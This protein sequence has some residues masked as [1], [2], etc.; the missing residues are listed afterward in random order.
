MQFRHHE[1]VIALPV[2]N[3]GNGAIAV[4]AYE[5]WASS[6]L[7]ELA[8]SDLC[9]PQIEYLQ[10]DSEPPGYGGETVWICSPSHP[11]AAK[12]MASD[13]FVQFCIDSEFGHAA[14][15]D[16]VSGE[17][18]HLP[19]ER[20]GYDPGSPEQIGYI[21]RLP[22]PQDDDPDNTI[23]I[24]S[25]LDTPGA[26]GAAHWYTREFDDDEWQLMP[27]ANSIVQSTPFSAIVSCRYSESPPFVLDSE[28]VALHRGD[29]KAFV[30]LSRS[31]LV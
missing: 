21:A 17:F 27:P 16:R 2:R 29:T 3:Y 10:E 12:L 1:A 8:A 24:L 25:G 31:E 22:Y 11:A 4:D 6:R 5:H 15:R 30:N 14:I 23:L 20:I 19:Q 9:E 26:A 28:L 13:P 7:V 18:H